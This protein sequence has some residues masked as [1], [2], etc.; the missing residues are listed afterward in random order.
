VIEFIRRKTRV[1]LDRT[2][3][4]MHPKNSHATTSSQCY[5]NVQDKIQA[6]QTIQRVNCTRVRKFLFELNRLSNRDKKE[7]EVGPQFMDSTCWVINTVSFSNSATAVF[8]LF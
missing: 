3:S 1:L 7:V 2:K 8:S 6:A 4:K 5:Q